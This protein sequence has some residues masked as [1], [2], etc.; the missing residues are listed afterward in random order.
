M[1][2]RCPSGI[3]IESVTHCGRDG[4]FRVRASRE[5][6]APFLEL[7]YRQRQHRNSASSR[8]AIA[9]V[10]AGR[11]AP[12]SACTR[13]DPQGRDPRDG[14]SRGRDP[15]ARRRDPAPA[16]AIMDGCDA[17]ADHASRSARYAATCRRNTRARDTTMMIRD[18]LAQTPRSCIDVARKSLRLKPPP[19]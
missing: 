5:R 13:G 16:D 7:G 10:E 6:A 2:H 4:A 1:A 19:A 15:R 18:A 9:P 17:Y 14:D 8:P 12:R 11:K 3:R